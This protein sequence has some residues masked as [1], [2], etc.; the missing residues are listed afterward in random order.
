MKFLKEWICERIIGEEI[1]FFDLNEFSDLENIDKG[2]HGT[3]KKTN[4]K[5]RKITIVLKPLKNSK[6]TES[7][8]KEFITK[9]KVLRKI[10]HS[11]INRFFGLT[12]DS[13][14]NYFSISEYASEGN[15]RDY[16]KI[17]FNALQ[18]DDKLQMALE[19]TRGLMCLHSENI[20]HGNLHAYNIVVNNSKVMMT[21]LQLIKQAAKVSSEYT[22]YIEPRCL[23]NSS[24]E[25]DTK[26]DIYSLGIL[27]WELSSGRPPFSE[28]MQ[29]EF[30]LTQIANKLLNGERE[31]PVANTPLEYLQLYQKC[32]ND[33]PNMRPEINEVY[34]ILSQLIDGKSLSDQS[35]SLRTAK[36]TQEIFN[37]SPQQTVRRFKLNHGIVLNGHDIIP[38]LQGVVVEDG[39]LRVNL[40]DGQPLVYTSIN[41]ENSELRRDICI[42]F[43][44]AEITY[45]GKLLESF[46][47]YTD[48][49]NKLHKLHGDFLAR[50]FLVGGKLFI[51]D[52]NLAA[53][54]QADILKYYL[55]CIY[56]SVKYSIEIQFNNLFTLD[57]L[58][59]LVT[60]DGEK[61][62]THEKLINWM[63][64]LYKK[65][66]VS[67]ISYDDLI[68]ISS[69]K[70][71]LPLLYGDH[72]DYKER[73]PGVADFEEK[74]NLD[75]WVGNAINNNLMNWARE[76]NLFQGLII[77][78]YGE[79]EIS[80]K[81]PIN[82]IKIPKVNSINKSYLKIIELSTKLEFSFISN[83]IFPIKNLSTF[84][85]IKNND[86]DEGHE[87]YNHVL[88][89]YEK[90]EILLNTESI[91]AT[92]EFEQAI[93]EALNGMNPLK[94]LQDVHDEYGH[95]FPRR[96]IL[97]RSLK[98]FLQNSP[99]PNVLYDFN[100]INELLK[101]IDNLN[102]SYLFT[103]K[104]RIIEKNDLYNWICNTNNRLEI[105]KFDD[106]IPLYKILK[107]ELQD[108]IDDL[109]KN[110]YKVIMTGITN[111][112]DLDNN[113]I[114]SNK[115]IDF[116]LS[117]ESEEYEVFGSIMSENNTKSEKIYVSFKLYDF[118]GF[119]ATIKKLEET[120]I[121]ITKCFVLWIVIGK[122]SQLSFLSPSN[123]ELR[124][125]IIEKSIKL[126]PDKLNDDIETTFTLREGYTVFAH[127]N[128]SPINYESNSIK[129]VRWNERSINVQIESDKIR[130]NKNSSNSL[131]N[132]SDHE[133][134]GCLAGE[135]VLR[136]CILSKGLK[137]D[138]AKEGECPLNLAGHILNK[139]NFN[140]NLFNE[141]DKNNVSVDIQDN[142]CP[143]T[144]KL[145]DFQL[146]ISGLNEEGRLPNRTS[147][148]NS[149]CS[150]KKNIDSVNY[151]GRFKLPEFGSTTLDIKVKELIKDPTRTECLYNLRL[152]L[153]D[154]LN[155][156][157]PNV[158]QDSLIALADPTSFNYYGKETVVSLELHMRT[159]MAVLE[160]ICFSPM[161]LKK[162]VRDKVYNSLKKFAEI[163]KKTQ[164]FHDDNRN[165]NIDFLLVHLRDTLNGLRDEETWFHE[166]IRTTK[167]SLKSML[168]I[169]PG[170]ASTNDNS[171]FL[172]SFT[173]LQQNLKYKYPVASYYV[174][175]RIILVIQHNLFTWCSNSE[176]I[177][178]KKYCEM[179]LME[180]LWSFLEREWTDVSNKFIL[181]S[182]TKFEEVSH[183]ATKILK[184]TGSFLNDLTGNEPN[185]LPHTLWFGILDL[186]QNLIQKSD[187]T[188]TYGLCYYLATESLNR[189]PSNFI[190]FKAIEILFHLN[191]IDKQLFSVIEIDLDQYIQKLNDYNL[192]DFSESFK[193]LLTF[194]KE[195]CV[196]DF[197]IS[198]GDI[199][200]KGKRK[201]KDPYQDTSFKN[202]QTSSS[203]ISNILNV[204]ADEM[205]CSISGEPTDQLCILKCQH[206]LSLNNL[207]KLK[208]KMCPKCRENFEDNDIN[209]IPQNSIYKN[210][211]TKF[212][213][214]GN[215]LPVNELELDNQYNSDSSDD[216][217]VDILIKKKKLIHSVK[218]NSQISLKSIFHIGK[219]QHPSYQN[220]M[221]ELNEKNYEKAETLW[222]EIL[223]SFPKSYSIK[224]ILAYIYRCLDNYKQAYLYLNEA[225]NLKEKKP[226]AW[227]IR[228][229]IYFRENMYKKAIDDL[230]TSISHKAKINNLYILLGINNLFE[231]EKT[232]QVN[233]LDDA[234]KNFNIVLQSSPNNSLCCKNCA[235]IYEKRENYLSTLK[236]L[237]YFLN[238]D[239]KD[240]LILCYYG[241]ILSKI[242]LYKDAIPY[243][244]KSNDNDPENVYNLI[245]RAIAYYVLQEYDKALLDLNKVMQLDS[246]N[247]L[248]YYYKGLT[249]Y[250]IGNVNDALL[251]F[252]KC[253]ELH[254]NDDYAK[255][256][257]YYLKYSPK[258][259]SS[260]ELNHNIIT[261]INQ[262]ADIYHNNLLF[263]R[264]KVY[265]ELEKYLEAKLDLDK[266]LTLNEEDI[267][268]IYLLREYSN[269]CSY[270]CKIY[271]INVTDFNEFG[272]IDKFGK[273]I[274]KVLNVYLILNL[275][276]LNNEFYFKESDS[277]SFS[278]QVLCLK[279]EAYHLN[280]PK[281]TNDF[282]KGF[283]YVVW[284]INVKKI[285]SKDCF[286][287]FLIIM[288]EK[289][290]SNMVYSQKEHLLNY[291]DLLKL[292]ESSWIEYTLPIKVDCHQSIQL[293][294]EA[295]KGSIDMQIDYVRFK[296]SFGNQTYFLKTDHP[297]PIH[298]LLPTVPEV[299]RDKYFSK[300]E[301]ENLLEL[302]D[303]LHK[304][305]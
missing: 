148:E 182:Q 40:Y 203:N 111:L 248:T 106:I 263:M 128:H 51:E 22:V 60:L 173:E 183:K 236:M 289:K 185:A 92:K 107:T 6:I 18:W 287:K 45:N 139:K 131:N 242:G 190:Q 235:Y 114:E 75:E 136:I 47:E 144:E 11:N 170:T 176:K 102:I 108:K 215:I 206:V 83:S 52:F 254:S 165:Y 53:T 194:V 49:E 55:F 209:Y 105:V 14:D 295:N 262:I 56:N 249:H 149:E 93:E 274:Y 25:L 219:K 208:H 67:I 59:K 82:V 198:N 46:I 300:K 16:L 121:D 264:C 151:R 231:A 17:K 141:S 288:E 48:D 166:V 171:S 50:R 207:K 283:Y 200:K 120:S 218:S 233:Y 110:N 109:L 137:I 292:G 21:D 220:A 143:T 161:R 27:L 98:N 192:T 140:V 94:A 271:E 202:K 199:E 294:I 26:S 125:D 157:S 24:Y 298:E 223:K 152:L 266:L 76:F 178:S 197:E 205:T 71:N 191:K 138:N 179:V 124:V 142:K 91:T 302:K 187:R 100:D 303:I 115:R 1:E 104:G 3:L 10:D 244:T 168:N 147:N 35:L 255:M 196:E 257:L 245:K 261:K 293:S 216:F 130:T 290:D 280:L 7:E 279:N 177:I 229:E 234:L 4:W 23:R 58:P 70:H 246:Q 195:K 237:E 214:S 265:I 273:L 69:L 217:E 222:K 247:G 73:Q 129:L 189:A 96:I 57:L 86:N 78:K 5:N 211:Y 36:I 33:D 54:P 227:Y 117:L 286:V 240:S 304:L 270:L 90:Y 113:N 97:G 186:A 77:N 160:Q 230:N 281:L 251:A 116:G 122:T 79:I 172:S 123:R 19:I 101:S 64:N 146:G 150:F 89:K 204:I 15:L 259:N 154:P 41:S 275:T 269:F 272:I 291:H 134:N 301:M 297:L 224:C 221:K 145:P 8:F 29:M 135:M 13:N 184:N 232:S 42:N 193:S 243:F 278:G 210:L 118:N 112:T 239:G 241:E 267:S 282:K 20:I 158:L 62:N 37:S 99:S 181:D 38:S 162:E 74:L 175:W 167:K 28:Y 164:V 72:E 2:I 284:K 163:H 188:S 31:E 174:N 32:W 39:K 260:K 250:A 119:Y 87:G 88:V 155:K 180:Y 61:I 226:I 63:N 127:V 65:K 225:I 132:D 201:I 103:Q 44:V 9:L 256:Q 34:D 85:F 299:F 296:E 66:M 252:M 12:K 212:S 156:F 305:K 84:P 30:G 159:L 126:L 228:G 253:I 153:E 133:D 238:V 68:P 277:N 80:K 169:S 285:L 258:N 268:I 43:P 276:N 81:A 213:E 95:L